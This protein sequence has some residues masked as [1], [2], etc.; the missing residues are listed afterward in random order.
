MWKVGS[1]TSN[2]YATWWYWTD[3]VTGN[4]RL[5]TEICGASSRTRQAADLKKGD[6]VC[7]NGG[8]K[9]LTDVY[10]YTASVDMVEEACI[11]STGAS[12]DVTVLNATALKENAPRENTV[13][14]QAGVNADVMAMIL[15]VVCALCQG[16]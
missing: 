16:R 11:G 15:V 7:C 14:S 2:N 3:I 8:D 6:T 12:A 5:V 9:I 4:H 1:S 10:K 13:R